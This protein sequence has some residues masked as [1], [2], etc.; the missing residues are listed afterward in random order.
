MDEEITTARLA[1]LFGVTKKTIADLG[2]RKIIEGGEKRGTWRM[3]LIGGLLL[4]T[5][6]LILRIPHAASLLAIGLCLCV[7]HV[8]RESW[9]GQCEC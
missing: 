3:R 4:F 6:D 5:A 1:K 8:C 2:K 7:G 9:A